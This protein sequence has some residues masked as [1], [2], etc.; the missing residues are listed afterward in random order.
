MAVWE[1]LRLEV[2]DRRIYFC[3]DSKAALLALK[4]VRMRSLLVREC[5][6][7]LLE[8]AKGRAVVL[9]WVPGHTGIQGNEAADFLAREGSSHWHIGPEPRLGIARC[10]KDGALRTWNQSQAEEVWT[11][12]QGMRQARLMLRGPSRVRTRELLGL[13]SKERKA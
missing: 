5:K 12:A 13:P 8:L 3:S 1:S 7:W 11:G 4:A 9:C 10:I 2:G 6:H